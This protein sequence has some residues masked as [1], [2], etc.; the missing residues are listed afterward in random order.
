MLKLGDGN[1]IGKRG[2]IGKK[3]ILSLL[4]VSKDLKN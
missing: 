1:K 3:L 4:I 2:K